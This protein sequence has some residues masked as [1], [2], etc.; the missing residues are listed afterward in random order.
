MT[1]MDRSRRLPTADEIAEINRTHLIDT[2]LAPADLLVLRRDRS[3]A[4][5]RRLFPLV[6][7]QRRRHSRLGAIRVHDHQDGDGRGGYSGRS[8]RNIVR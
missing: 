2:P 5:A 8:S 6:D 7:C 3:A 1:I 4:M